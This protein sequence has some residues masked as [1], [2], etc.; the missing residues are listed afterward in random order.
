MKT[1]KPF[2][3]QSCALAAAV[4][5]S[6]GC[7]RDPSGEGGT[8]ALVTTAPPRPGVVLFYEPKSPAETAA[9]VKLEGEDLEIRPIIEQAEAEAIQAVEAY[10]V[11]ALSLQRPEGKPGAGAT[12]EMVEKFHKAAD[13]KTARYQGLIQTQRDRYE[14]FLKKYPDNWYER[15]RYA[16]FLAD[17]Q[18]ADDAAAEWRRVIEQAPAFPY[19]YN[20]LA[21]LYNHMGRDL[22]A[23]L[24]YRKAIELYPDD[25]DFHLNLA[26]N[27]STHRAEAAKEFGWDLPQVFHECILSYQR[28]RALK[29]KD[30][31]IAYNL[32]SQYVLA[33]F[34][35]VQSSADEAIEAWRYYLALDLTPAQR[36]VG[37][38]N[39]ASIYLRQKSDPAAAQKLLEEALT[40]MPGDPTCKMLL[41][42]AKAAQTK[43]AP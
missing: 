40:L 6:A 23:I 24:L 13:E 36:A 7:A 32:A 19:A 20:N 11:A 29:P 2:L 25:A 14:D 16:W 22:E 18:L 3:R 10:H 37:D 41:D 21:T 9:A 30:P 12:K 26:V 42:Q 1:M 39:L 38:R 27:Y 8:S 35:G 4:L 34:F 28:A 33:K 5:L 17:N 31:E 43:P 15:H